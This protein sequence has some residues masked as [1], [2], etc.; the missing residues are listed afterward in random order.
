[1]LRRFSKVINVQEKTPESVLGA[2]AAESLKEYSRAMDFIVQKEWAEAE[3]ELEKCSKIIE[4]SGQA[5]EPSHNFVLQRIAITQRAQGK[6]SKCEETL[7][8][9]V[10]NYQVNSQIYRDQLEFSYQ[11]L[12]KQYL[13]SNI[14]KAVKLGEILQ[15][16]S[17]WTG[18]K[19]ETQ[20]N[21]KFFYAVRFM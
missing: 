13:A 4:N 1:M 7:E 8:K 21:V 19:K 2:E 15:S 9:V 11:T 6:Y 20:K 18:L 5:L 16:P 14:L 12:Y 17:L 10:H 3:K